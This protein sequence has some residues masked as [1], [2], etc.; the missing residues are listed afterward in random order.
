MV[1]G[2]TVTFVALGI[3]IAVAIVGLLIDKSADH[4][5]RSE[6]EFI[7]VTRHK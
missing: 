7:K 5:E 4:A 2:L 6:T 3:T 1:L